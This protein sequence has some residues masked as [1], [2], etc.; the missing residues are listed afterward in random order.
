M[1]CL[2]RAKFIQDIAKPKIEAIKAETKAEYERQKWRILSDAVLQLRK[3]QNCNL[4]KKT[5]KRK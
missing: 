1:D 2:E 5:H 4:I 3:K